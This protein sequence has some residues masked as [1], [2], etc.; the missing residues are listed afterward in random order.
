MATNIPITLKRFNG[1]TYDK[2]LPTTYLG[3]LW[4]DST[5]TTSLSDYLD[6]RFAFSNTIAQANGLAT[7]GADGKLTDTQVPDYLIGGMRFKNSISLHLGKTVDDVVQLI[8][9]VG[10]YVIV[11][12]PGELSQGT[13]A[14]GS[15]R[16]PGDEG[17]STLPIVLEAGDWIVVSAVDGQNFTFAIVN[18]TY[19]N[20][21]TAAFG[22]TRLSPITNLTNASGNDVITE[23]VLAGLRVSDGTDLSDGVTRTDL[24]APAAHNHDSRYYTETEINA[25]FGGTS[26]IT[27][28]NDDNWNL[29]YND[30]IN[31]VEFATGTG[32]LTLNQ[33]D[34]TTLTVDLDGRYAESITAVQTDSTDG[35]DVSVTGNS[36]TIAHHDTSSV[37]DVT[38]TAG[39]VIQSMT[40]DTFGHLQTHATV[41]LDGRYYTETEFNTWLNGQTAIDEHK[42]T[43]ILY[44]ASPTAVNAGT[45]IIDTQV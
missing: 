8:T 3:Q 9:E 20:A 41:D 28:Y 32:V 42:F 19:Q 27:G 31:S 26:S 38:N 44:G 10:E 25:F 23:G 37:A 17:D 34:G 15:V 16:A 29:A 13:I 33:Q 11:T 40:F 36:Y 39:S 22:V 35:I 21:S 4:T 5:L 6:G 12:S 7:L 18:N 2:I 24:I 30:K 14:T 1:T 45:I 43:E